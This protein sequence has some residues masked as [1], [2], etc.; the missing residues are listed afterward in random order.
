MIVSSGGGSAPVMAAHAWASPPVA[1]SWVVT[2]A[3]LDVDGERWI[4]YPLVGGA[5]A[6]MVWLPRLTRVVPAPSSPSS[7]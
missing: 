6:L 4:V 3:T 1:G 7:R 5:L 2:Y